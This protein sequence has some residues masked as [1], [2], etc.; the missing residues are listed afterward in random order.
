ME[1]TADICRLFAIRIR[2]QFGVSLV[3]SYQ[4][5]MICQIACYHHKKKHI[6]IL[7]AMAIDVCV[8][9][10]D[11]FVY[12]SQ[13][14]CI[15]L[16]IHSR[17]HC[18]SIF[19][20]TW[21]ISW[22]FSIISFVHASGAIRFLLLTCLGQ[23]NRW[24][25]NLFF[26]HTEL[27]THRETIAK[28]SLNFSETTRKESKLEH[29]ANIFIYLFVRMHPFFRWWWWSRS[30]GRFHPRTQKISNR[31]PLFLWF[32]CCRQQFKVERIPTFRDWMERGK[33]TK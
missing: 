6:L 22:K 12:A 11:A 8:R 32:F 3:H 17:T 16:I 14:S 23:R 15:V 24:L 5:K 2:T 25:P 10:C 28:Y 1:G 29:Q 20:L 7:N 21:G 30:V 33:G 4:S 9:L 18:A 19:H 13:N 27:N 31:R 26:D